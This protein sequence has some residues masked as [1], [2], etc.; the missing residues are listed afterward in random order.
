MEN[1]KLNKEQ[2]A[3]YD[4]L[5]SG[6]NAFI[7]GDAG[8]GKSYLIN[9]FIE[10]RQSA[11]YNVV[12]CAPTG[13]AAINVNGSTIHRTFQAPLNPILENEKVKVLGVLVKADTVIIDEISM[14]RFD[15]FGYVAKC[16][17]YANKVRIE[18]HNKPSIQLVVVGDFFQLPPVMRDE[19]R[20]IFKEYYGVDVG[21]GFAFQSPYWKKF[22]FKNL[23]LKESMRQ[24]DVDFIN[25]L[26]AARVGDKGSIKFFR[27]CSRD[28]EIDN[29]IY[30][31]GT[32]KKAREQN[33]YKFSKIDGKSYTYYSE[34]EG[35]VK[36]SDKM[37]ED[38]L[39][40]KVG[41]RVMAL[42]NDKNDR[43]QNGSLGEV[44]E[45][46]ENYVIVRFDNG[47]T[48]G[49]DRYCWEIKGYSLKEDKLSKDTIGTF[50]QLPLKLAFAITIHKS[51]GQTYD[52]VNLNPFCWDCGQLYVALSRVRGI[53][54]LHIDGFLS[55]KYLI[56][57]KDVLAFYQSLT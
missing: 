34:I 32:N 38:E 47:C 6:S 5:M 12:V 48:V 11:G 19:T 29:A 15:L 16:I 51:Q 40:L 30:L 50:T 57:S 55:E 10:S 22:Q 31:C 2:Q 23:V 7:T 3:Y 46:R 9:K 43:F 28:S 44:I 39:T 1:S 42:I 27:Y 24:K 21:Y 13:V 17:G 26:N 41:A 36:D 14:C 25:N 52:S 45:C 56:V 53:D 20:D 54:G 49:V 8:V 37:T 35:D 18:R 33:D 4:I